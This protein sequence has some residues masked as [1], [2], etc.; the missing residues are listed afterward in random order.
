M[1]GRQVKVAVYFQILFLELLKLK[2]LSCSEEIA[3]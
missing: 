2:F 3:M 1:S